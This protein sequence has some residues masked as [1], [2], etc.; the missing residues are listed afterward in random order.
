MILTGSDCLDFDILTVTQAQ[1][2]CY[3]YVDEVL[4]ALDGVDIS[5]ED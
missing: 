2:A 4:A 1:S 5:L 3:L